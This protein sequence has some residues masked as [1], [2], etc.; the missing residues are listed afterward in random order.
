M[1]KAHDDIFDIGLVMH[2]LS[3]AAAGPASF[4]LF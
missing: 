4:D 2:R 3:R 1:A